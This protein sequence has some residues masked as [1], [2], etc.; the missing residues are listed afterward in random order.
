MLKGIHLTLLIGPG[1]PLPA[2]KLLVDALDSIQVTNSKERS[3]FQISFKVGKNSPILTTML[4][5]G[6]FEPIV[7]RVVVMVTLNGLPNVLMDGLVSN[8]EL[9]PSNE[10]GK[11]TFTI[12]GEDLSLAMDLIQKVLPYPGM[13]KV[14]QVN[15]ALAPYLALGVV[16]VVVPPPVISIKS[17]TSGWSSQTKMTD[18]A[19]VKGL[20]SQAGYIFVVQPGPLPGQ[21]IAYFGPDI[22][23]PIPQP[24]LSINLDSHT[25]V[26][27]LSF[28]LDGQA[29]KIRVM[30]IYDPI[31]QKVPIPIP[32]PNINAFK[33]PMGA[34]PPIPK[35]LEFDSESAR[36]APDE[37][38][39][40]ILGALMNNP[41]SITASGSL[42]VL[43]Y[44]GILRAR[45]L[46]GVRG[47]GLAYDGMYYVDSVT[48]NIKKGEY[49]QSFNLSRDGLI[50]NTPLVI[51]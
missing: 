39:E 42:N 24:A 40:K 46:V 26:E 41:P 3:G 27:N 37:A 5:A 8:Q 17:P 35:K 7:T 32:V 51:V 4:P 10:A 19:F 31:T 6:F 14:A 2:P 43:E 50:S 22:S 34:R 44:R 36:F 29:K 45:M 18:R 28:S 25:N 23:L 21:S 48:H 47:G 16:P 13:P 9:G 1:V 15:L 20:A 12:T 38:A 33:P 11:S 49:K 30:T